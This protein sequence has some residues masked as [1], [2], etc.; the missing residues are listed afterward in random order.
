MAPRWRPRSV[1]GPREAHLLPAARKA[2]LL[3]HQL[4]LAGQPLLQTQQELHGTRSRRTHSP[5]KAGSPGA[6]GGQAEGSE[7][8]GLWGA[9]ST[10]EA[11]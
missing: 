2:L 5:V 8:L 9:A 6:Q 11:Q 4:T 3:K 1:P 10:L 7:C